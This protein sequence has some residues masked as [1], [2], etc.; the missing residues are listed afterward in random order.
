LSL[1]DCARAFAGFR[2]SRVLAGFFVA[3]LA[4]RIAVGQWSWLD[5]AVAALLIASQPFAEW[6]IHVFLLHSKPRKLGPVTIDLPTAR[7]HRWH[8]E[9]PAVLE[10]VLIPASPIAAFLLPVMLVMW[11]LSWPWALPDH[12]T[13][14]KSETVKTL[15]AR[16]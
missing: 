9:N 6:L 15:G 5:L 16:A 2:S 7:L 11:L 10:A 13:V 14:P 3:I 4:A 1:L 8:H 12:R